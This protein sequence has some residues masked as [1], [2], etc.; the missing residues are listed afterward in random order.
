MTDRGL[1]AAHPCVASE[2]AQVP[3]S[4]NV[5]QG[6]ANHAAVARVLVGARFKIEPSV[7]SGSEM[8]G[9]IPLREG[10]GHFFLQSPAS[11][12]A[13]AEMRG[14]A[15]LRHRPGS[16]VEVL[17]NPVH[18]ERSRPPAQAGQ[19][20]FE[21]LE[22]AEEAARQQRI[23]AAGSGSVTRVERSRYGAGYVVRSV[24][25]RF[26]SSPQLRQLLGPLAR[27]YGR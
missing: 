19:S 9:R 27:N 6:G 5:V 15:R 21:S 4:R 26:L 13:R 11:R 17:S 16:G 18:S 20:F 2:A 7:F 24:P 25:V 14:Y 8:L 3:G 1:F 22:A 12:P 10:L 23:H